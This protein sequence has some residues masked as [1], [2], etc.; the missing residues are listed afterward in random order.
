MY[1]ALLTRRQGEIPDEAFEGEE[2]VFDP[3]DLANELFDAPSGDLAEVL[4][5]AGTDRAN[6]DGTPEDVTAGAGAAALGDAAEERI[7]SQAS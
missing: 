7:P 5:Q 1:Q 6:T 4:G 2:E 3:D